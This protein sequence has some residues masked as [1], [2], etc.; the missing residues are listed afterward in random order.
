MHEETSAKLYE[1][2][3]DIAGYTDI[4][5]HGETVWLDGRFDVKELEQ[6]LEAMKLLKVHHLQIQS[7]EA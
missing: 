1:L 4:K 7:H 2:T 5:P 6:I 3:K